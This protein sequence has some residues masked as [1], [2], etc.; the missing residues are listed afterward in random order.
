MSGFFGRLKRV[1]RFRGV[2]PDTLTLLQKGGSPRQLAR[3]IRSA[4]SKRRGRRTT[5]RSRGQRL[6]SGAGSNNTFIFPTSKLSS[7]S[8][9]DRFGVNQSSI[10]SGGSMDENDTFVYLANAHYNP[11]SNGLTMGSHAFLEPAAHGYDLM[12]TL[13][14]HY[15][16]T[17]STIVVTAQNRTNQPITLGIN[18][19]DEILIQPNSNANENSRFGKTLELPAAFSEVG[20]VASDAYVGVPGVM[21]TLSFSYSP[22]I[23]YRA[24][25]VGDQSRLRGT[26]SA[27]VIPTELAAFHVWLTGASGAAPSEGSVALII[28]INYHVRSIEPKTLA[29]QTGS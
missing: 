17:K 23:F 6:R 25:S 3:S 20:T 18:L 14:D 7:H 9:I 29:V 2:D 28:R 24:R 27:A 26:Y 8:L 19:R 15:F 1:N 13:Y 4:G 22:Q 10:G 12:A 16:V 11:K 5:F 21:K